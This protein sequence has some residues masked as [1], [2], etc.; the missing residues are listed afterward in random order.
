MMPSEPEPEL[1]TFLT[2][3]KPSRTSSDPRKEM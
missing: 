3:W 2:D 1:E